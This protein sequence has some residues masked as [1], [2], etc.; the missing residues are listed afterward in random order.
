MLQFITKHLLMLIFFCFFLFLDASLFLSVCVC[1]NK[2]TCLLYNSNGRSSPCYTM[3]V[4]E[5]EI[6][7]FET[8]HTTFSVNWKIRFIH[9]FLKFFFKNN[10][11]FNRRW[12]MFNDN[13]VL[14]IFFSLHSHVTC[15]EWFQ[16]KTNFLKH[17]DYLQ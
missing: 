6:Y 3:R 12:Q 1:E 5:R 14:T 8:A 9:S 10:F 7:R 13:M 2:S 4:I 17:M 11:H 15:V 16:M